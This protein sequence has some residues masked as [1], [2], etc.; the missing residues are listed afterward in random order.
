MNKPSNQWKN[1]QVSHKDISDEKNV[2]FFQTAAERE[3]LQNC[4][5]R[6]TE[7]EDN[8]TDNESGKEKVSTLL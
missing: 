1:T 3:S 7:D 5:G 4:V 2:V 6:D 8:D